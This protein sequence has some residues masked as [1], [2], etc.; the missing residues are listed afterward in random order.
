VGKATTTLTIQP[1]EGYFITDAFELGIIPSLTIYDL[2]SPTITEFG[3]YLAPS[4]NFN[5]QSNLFPFIEGR[6]GYNSQSVKYDDEYSE[7]DYDISGFAWGLRGGLKVQVGSSALINM[8]ITYDQVNLNE[9]SD[10]DRN[11]TNTFGI[12]A[13][14]TIFLGK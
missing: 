1:Y 7:Y 10:D 13:G 4:Y 8:A 14:F 6:I 11:G 2:N 12:N 3:I 9:D 5:L